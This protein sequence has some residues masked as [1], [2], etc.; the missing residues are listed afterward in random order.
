MK[1][2]F[3]LASAT[4]A[5]LMAFALPA[6]ARHARC[7][8]PMDQW[9]PREALQQKLEDDGWQ[10]HKIKTEDGCY[11]VDAVNPDGIR[12]EA[13]FDPQTFDLIPSKED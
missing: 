9:Q 6:A 10:I 8:V 3:V 13:Y 1:K 4:A 11:E 12:L 5:A 2:S 7:D